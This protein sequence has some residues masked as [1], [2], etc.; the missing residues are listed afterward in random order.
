MR[1]AVL[2]RNRATVLRGTHGPPAR[3]A[4]LPRIAW[5]AALPLLA[6]CVDNAVTG[7]TTRTTA[8]G[9]SPL[10]MM[11]TLDQEWTGAV[12]TDWGTAGNWLSGVVPDSASGVDIPAASLLTNQPLLGADAQITDLR[13]GSAST[14]DLGGFTLTSWGS[15]ES[16]GAVANGQLFMR[17]PGALLA[18]TV[19]I[20]RIDGRVSVEQPVLATGSVSVPGG[21]L[22]LRD[23]VLSIQL[24]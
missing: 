4:R 10:M 9:Q 21:S 7:P 16:I 15:V 5:L 3:R 19:N 17:G 12:S 24:P 6:A 1:P 14:L 20:L 11:L 22:S 18:G 23:S 13:V 8:P 2:A